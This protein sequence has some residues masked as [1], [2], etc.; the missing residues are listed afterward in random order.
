MSIR[1]VPRPL[2]KVSMGRSPPLPPGEASWRRR[3]E[4]DLDPEADYSLTHSPD[5]GE[6]AANAE[7]Y[8]PNGRIMG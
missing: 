6:N 3:Y 8:S 1:S 2:A 7:Y 5:A 4:K